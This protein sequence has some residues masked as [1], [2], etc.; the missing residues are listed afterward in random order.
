MDQLQPDS[1]DI[2]MNTTWS[3]CDAGALMCALAPGGLLVQL[4][5]P[6]TPGATGTQSV[7]L[8]VDLLS[9]VPKQRRVAGSNV[10]SRAVT[11]RMLAFAAKKGIRPLVEVLPLAKINDAVAKMDAG[12]QRYRIVLS[13]ARKFRQEE[14]GSSSSELAEE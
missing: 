12:E 4:G 6:W 1:C 11:A 7:T 10:G 2:V 13:T 9:L 3:P 14:G 8:G 5:M